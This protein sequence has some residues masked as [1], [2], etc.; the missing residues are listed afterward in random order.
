MAR[1]VA[2][3]AS[4]VLVVMLGILVGLRVARRPVLPEIAMTVE[5]GDTEHHLRVLRV[6]CDVDGTIGWFGGDRRFRTIDDC[7]PRLIEFAAAGGTHVA[8]YRQ[9]DLP[10]SA[11]QRQVM[12]V[13]QEQGL[14]LL[15][16]GDPEFSTWVGRSGEILRDQPPVATIVRRRSK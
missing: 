3:C 4:F 5:D 13:A 12:L 11:V 1:I 2:T 14:G 15:Q 6:V 8:I 9:P 16:S 7:A 10:P